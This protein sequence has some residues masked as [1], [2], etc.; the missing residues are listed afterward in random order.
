MGVLDRETPLHL[1]SCNTDN[2]P[3]ETSIVQNATEKSVAELFSVY[4]KETPLNLPIDEYVHQDPLCFFIGLFILHDL[5]QRVLSSILLDRDRHARYLR[6][7]LNYLSKWLVALDASKPWLTYWILHSLDLL[8]SE[9]SP[10][11]IQ[12]YL[13]IG[14]FWNCLYDSAGVSTMSKWQNPDGGFS[15]GP[16][17]LSH[18]AP[19]Y[20]TINS[21]A[22]IGTEEAYAIINRDT[23]YKFLMRMK[24]P[25]GS[26]LMH[27]GGEI[28]IRGLYCALSV[29][30][31]TNLL[32]PELTENCTQFILRCQTYEGGIGPYPGMEAHGGYA[33]CGIAALEILGETHLLDMPKFIHWTVSRQ[34]ALE[35]GFQGRTNKLVDGCYSFW[36]GGVFALIEAELVRQRWRAGKEVDYLM[37]REALQEY[38]LVACQDDDG[39]LRDKPHKG[40]DYYHTCYC[41]SGLS[42]AQHY[43]S[44]DLDAV[45]RVQKRGLDA[46]RGGLS[47]LMWRDG[48]E[49][50]VLGDVENLVVATHPV[51]NVSL[52][53][54]R[55]ILEYFYAEDVARVRD[56]LP[57]ESGPLDEVVQ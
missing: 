17:Q 45:E 55:R 3:T 34:M 32:T 46:T 27:D 11:I 13:S 25:D 16:N 12:R 26:F 42:I 19:T 50:V 15:G 57:R 35:G 9:I 43:T 41:L 6:T 1:L 8:E 2:L 22:I 24:Q 29:A 4:R 44:V 38:I 37:D 53:K 31:M 21:I 39:G 56:L 7:G 51:H 14:S 40:P 10:D 47:S 23:L 36:I 52:T 30:S 28:D 48:D 49:Y 5:M 18:L 33:F 54:T 20:A